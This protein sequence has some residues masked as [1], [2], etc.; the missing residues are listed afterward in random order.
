[1]SKIKDHVITFDMV[2]HT[3]NETGEM[4]PIE[5]KETSEGGLAKEYLSVYDVDSH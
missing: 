5:L 2:V 3:M 1:M 4:I